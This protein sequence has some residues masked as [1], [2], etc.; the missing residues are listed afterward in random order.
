MKKLV[1]FL[2]ASIV[3][4]IAGCDMVIDQHTVPTPWV[5]GFEKENA[6]VLKVGITTKDEISQYF[7]KKLGAGGLM[8]SEVW[9][10]GSYSCALN[11]IGAGVEHK[12]GFL[13]LGTYPVYRMVYLIFPDGADTLAGYQMIED[14]RDGTQV[15]VGGQTDDQVIA[16]VSKLLA[17][18]K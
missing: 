14:Y 9:P 10:C 5:K 6:N 17:Q 11:K 12:R 16:E 7:M 4:V 18:K 8:P 15:Q 1:A 3:F 2:F 13:G